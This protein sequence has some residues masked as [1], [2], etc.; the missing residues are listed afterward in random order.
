MQYI[1][2][3]Y[4]ER[5]HIDLCK[6]GYQGNNWLHYPGGRREEGGDTITWDKLSGGRIKLEGGG[7]SLR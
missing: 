4:K 2:I 5:K 6:M 7:G 1:G 3:L